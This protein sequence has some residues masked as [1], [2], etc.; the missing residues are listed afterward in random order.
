MR[1]NMVLTGDG[2]SVVLVT[3]DDGEISMLT[4][5]HPHFVRIGQ[6]LL[7]GEDPSQFID[8]TYEPDAPSIEDLSDRVSIVDGVLHFD[9]DPVYDALSETILRY[10]TEERDPYNIVRFMERLSA[11]PSANSREQLFTWAQ[12]KDLTID[13]NGFLIA[14]KGVTEDML[15]L[16]SGKARVNGVEHEGQIPNVIGA[17]VAMPRSEVNDN[18]GVGCS[19]GLHVGSWSYASGFGPLTLEVRIDPANV[20]S[21]PNDC[22]FQKMRVCEYEVVAVHERPEDDL[23]DYEPAPAWDEDEAWNEFA[24]AEV[25]QGILASLRARLRKNRKAQS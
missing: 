8:G 23:S 14:Y 22:S 13:P 9:G 17:V 18:T 7:A 6:A 2:R 4:D 3:G 21:V 20:V 11:N 15:S 12:A 5:D 10:R 24:A 19:T 25:P 1:F 16:S